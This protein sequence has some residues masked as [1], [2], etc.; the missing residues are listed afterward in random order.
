MFGRWGTTD[1]Y[2]ALFK[3]NYPISVDLERTGTETQP[4]V[5]VPDFKT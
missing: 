1:S 5:D 4:K 2:I 3:I